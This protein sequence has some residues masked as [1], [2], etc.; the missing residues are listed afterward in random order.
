MKE[1][2]ELK[3]V[4]KTLVYVDCIKFDKEKLNLLNKIF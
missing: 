4:K 2:D 1:Y 3:R